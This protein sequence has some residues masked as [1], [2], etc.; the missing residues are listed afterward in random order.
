MNHLMLMLDGFS[1]TVKKTKKKQWK[2]NIY[3]TIKFMHNQ[4]TRME[5]ILRG[6]GIL[7]QFPRLPVQLVP[8][9]CGVL[10]VSL[11]K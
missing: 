2:L 11:Y 9:I 10:D 1:A 3:K 5:N 7:L 6:D 8:T 4:C